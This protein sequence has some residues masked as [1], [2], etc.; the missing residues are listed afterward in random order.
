MARDDFIEIIKVIIIVARSAQHL[1]WQV[2]D[3]WRSTMVQ[4]QKLPFQTMPRGELALTRVHDRHFPDQLRRLQTTGAH[5]DETAI[6]RGREEEQR[7][8]NGCLTV[9][10][11]KQFSRPVFRDIRLETVAVTSR[12]MIVVGPWQHIVEVYV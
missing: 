3:N 9:F 7:T 10:S 1:E 2:S 11:F 12:W 8:L 4:E 6:K 5:K